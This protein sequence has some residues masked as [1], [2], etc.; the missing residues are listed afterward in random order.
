MYTIL[1]V[2]IKNV[3]NQMYNELWQHRYTLWL[4]FWSEKAIKAHILILQYIETTVH[5]FTPNDYDCNYQII[6]DFIEIISHIML[7][8]QCS[9]KKT[10]LS[11]SRSMCSSHVSGGRNSR[12]L[13]GPQTYLAFIFTQ[14]HRLQ[15]I[16]EFGRRFLLASYILLALAI[17]YWL[18]LLAFVI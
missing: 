9:L 11:L 14:A 13:I 5:R 6:Y 16:T 7:Q 10:H 17:G 12:I 15:H 8:Q 18:W 3:Q 4:Y 1:D 2:A